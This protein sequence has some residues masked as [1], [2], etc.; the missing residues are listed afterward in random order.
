MEIGLV[1]MDASDAAKGKIQADSE[2]GT[3]GRHAL[4]AWEWRLM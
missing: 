4:H 3:A 1:A 2:S